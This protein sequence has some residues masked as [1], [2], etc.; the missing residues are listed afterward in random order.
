VIYRDGDWLAA[1]V[2]DEMVMMSATKGNYIGLSPVGARIWELLETPRSME[3]LCGA[4]IGE[5]DVDP[6]TCRAEVDSFIAT[7]SQQQAVRID[8]AG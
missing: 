1:K 3:S 6:A 7:L 5:Y 8:D 2:G 4:L